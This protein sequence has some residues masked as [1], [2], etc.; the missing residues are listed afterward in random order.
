MQLWTVTLIIWSKIGISTSITLQYKSP[1]PV[2]LESKLGIDF[3]AGV[4]LAYSKLT[5]YENI[6]TQNIA[7]WQEYKKNKEEKGKNN[8]GKHDMQEV[9]Y[10]YGK[11]NSNMDNSAL[12]C[13]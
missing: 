5:N 1:Y 11:K 2:P 10:F 9:F 6:T 12:L 7:L 13:N 8:Q 4:E 3:L